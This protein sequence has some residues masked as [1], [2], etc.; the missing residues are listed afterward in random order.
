MTAL[1]N[2]TGHEII[3]PYIVVSKSP[4]IGCF[5]NTSTFGDCQ[6]HLIQ[7]MDRDSIGPLSETPQLYTVE[8][9]VGE[10]NGSVSRDSFPLLRTVSICRHERARILLGY[11]EEKVVK[12]NLPKTFAAL[13]QR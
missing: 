11:L 7:P 4:Q 3:N 1:D 5:L 10:Y 9:V 12:A 2:E 8:A 13:N 6:E